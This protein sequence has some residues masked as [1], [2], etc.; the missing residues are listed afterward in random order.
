MP[1]TFA[2]LFSRCFAIAPALSSASLSVMRAGSSLRRRRETS[3]KKRDKQQARRKMKLFSVSVASVS[4]CH[5]S[6]FRQ[7]PH[8]FAAALVVAVP[9]VILRQLAV[10]A[11]LLRRG[12]EVVRGTPGHLFWKKR[13]EEERE[14]NHSAFRRRKMNVFFV[15]LAFHFSFCFYTLRAA[16]HRPR[17]PFFPCCSKNDTEN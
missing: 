4:N 10:G 7:N 11:A 2:L 9:D 14:G 16:K 6:S 5:P 13:K 12:L 15:F 17:P 1:S 8:L 3:E